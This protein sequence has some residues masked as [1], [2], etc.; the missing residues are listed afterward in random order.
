MVRDG[1]GR[2]HH[3]GDE[4]GHRVADRQV[5]DRRV[6]DR[7]TTDRAMTDPVTTGRAT[8]D[9]A[10]ADR[11]RR[12]ARLARHATTVRGVHHG[13]RLGDGTIARRARPAIAR[14]ARGHPT[15]MTVTGTVAAIATQVPIG[16]RTAIGIQTATAIDT[17]IGTVI[18]I[19]GRRTAASGTRIVGPRG[20]VRHLATDLRPCRRPMP[21]VPTRSL[22]RV[23]G[24][25][26]RRSSRADR[27]DDCWSSRTD[28]TPLRSSCC[29][30]R[31]CVSPSWRS[32]VA[33]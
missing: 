2:I 33:R 4:V 7:V 16:I 9:P 21:S 30:P 15:H 28:A 19:V 25:S 8:T 18:G 23:G 1:R 14:A 26:K 20:I 3:K 29:T 32:R 17:R 24:P 11:A 12:V 6:R 13:L 5:G 31:T 27:L 10:M 22:S